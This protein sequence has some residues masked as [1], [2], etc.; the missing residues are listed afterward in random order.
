[1]I[2]SPSYSIAENGALDSSANGLTLGQRKGRQ[3]Y[4]KMTVLSFRYSGVNAPREHR[5]TAGLLSVETLYHWSWTI[6]AV[7]KLEL[8]I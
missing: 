3:H 8:D 7:C 6:L 1:M 2:C 4:A 5:S